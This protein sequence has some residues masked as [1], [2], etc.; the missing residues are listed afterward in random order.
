MFTQIKK[1]P[2]VRVCHQGCDRNLP[3]DCYAVNIGTLNVRTLYDLDFK[4]RKILDEMK[5]L[6]ISILGLS[7]THWSNETPEAFEMND[8]VI[9]QSSRHDD[10]HRQGVAT[11]LHKEIAKHME[12]FKT[13][14]ER[15]ILIQLETIDEPLFILQGYAPDSTY[16]EEEIDEFY[17][18]VQEQL[19]QLPK[20]RKLILLGDFNAKVGNDAHINWAGVAGRYGIGQRNRSGDKL[21]QF[22][23][24]NVL[25]IMNTMYKQPK[26]RLVTWISPDGKTQN[27]IDYILIPSS[28]K[29]LVKAVGS[30]ILQT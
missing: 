23:G 16:S 20:K 25:S 15:L 29:Y 17:H 6:N 28:Q 4:L 26:Q 19:D 21:L 27:Q 13:I 30:T 22:S 2:P 18:L 7:E 24:L 9:V 10:I 14:S 5:R 11:V 8:Y 3:E 1:R 12:G